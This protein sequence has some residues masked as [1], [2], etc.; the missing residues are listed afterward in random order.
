VKH[1]I[2]ITIDEDGVMHSEVEGVAGSLC[3]GLTAWLNR[4]GKVLKHEKTAD[5]RK[6]APVHLKERVG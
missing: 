2:N 4:L 6:V 3:E 5:Y 1:I